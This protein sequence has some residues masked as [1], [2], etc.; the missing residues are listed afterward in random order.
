MIVFNRA[1]ASWEIH[2]DTGRVEGYIR[3]NDA[4]GGFDVLGQQASHV[5]C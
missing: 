5:V 4:I 3:P 2:S 1:T